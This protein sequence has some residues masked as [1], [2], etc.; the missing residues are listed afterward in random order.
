MKE[1]W[2]QPDTED[3]IRNQVRCEIQ[4][5][6]Y[7]TAHRNSVLTRITEYNFA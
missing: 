1:K 2:F 4:Q 5:R 7:L 3:R 6:L